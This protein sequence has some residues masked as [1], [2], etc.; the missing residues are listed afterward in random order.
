MEAIHKPQYLTLD[1]KRT[2][3]EDPNR[4]VWYSSN[5][6]YWTDDWS[7]LVKMGPGIPCCP[8]CKSPG[9]QSVAYQFLRSD[10][11]SALPKKEQCKPPTMTSWPGDTAIS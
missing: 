2:I 9:F 4:G 6:Y 1:G 10:G 3:A 11:D 5:C 8:V 7:K